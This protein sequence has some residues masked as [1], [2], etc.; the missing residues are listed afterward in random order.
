MVAG[1]RVPMISTHNTVH[2]IPPP[3][4]CP[5][6][7]QSPIQREACTQALA[8][9]KLPRLSLGPGSEQ[10]PSS[11][12]GFPYG[13]IGPHPPAQQVRYTPGA[14]WDAC[15]VGAK[16]R[17]KTLRRSAGKTG[18]MAKPPAQSTERPCKA[19]QPCRGCRYSGKDE[20]E[21]RGHL[22]PPQRGSY[23][24]LDALGL[25]RGAGVL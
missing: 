17:N 6:R 5:Y 18:T 2:G 12:G 9:N 8:V 11:P 22:P 25:R 10:F 4:A 7:P 13:G 21:A 19:R 23:R 1:R 16:H 3:A 15:T 24:A 14:S 20:R